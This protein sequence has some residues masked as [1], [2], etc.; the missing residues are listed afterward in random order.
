MT[1]IRYETTLE[2]IGRIT[3]TRPEVANAVRPATMEALCAA[4]DACLA[5][6]SVRAIVLTGEGRN[7]A[8]GA[9]FDYLR[10]LFDVETGDVRAN[11]YAW[12]RGAAERLWRSPKP[13]VAAVRGAAITVGCELA[14]V[15][16][17]RVASARSRFGEIWLHLGLIPPLGGAVLLPRI[18]GLTHAKRM[19]LEAAVI[20]GTEALAIGLVDE[21]VDDDAILA[22]A[23]QRALAMAAFPPAAFAA[24]KAALHR[25]FESTMDHEWNSNVLQQ[26]M[27]IG[28]EE[29]RAAVRA[30][31]ERG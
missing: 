9:D 26:A 29:F 16:D 30:R 18:V 21:L 27:L 2:G 24:A 5:D 6:D 4:I 10:G 25:G 22:R 12:F 13:T 1:D 8:A 17:A 20:D 11:L 19:I 14:L 15:C 3:I 23:E 28:T 31:G 7:F